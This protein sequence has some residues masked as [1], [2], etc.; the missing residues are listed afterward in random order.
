[1]RRL[2]PVLISITASACLTTVAETQCIRNVDCD[3]GICIDG[4]CQPGT[5]GGV[6]SSGGGSASGGGVGTTGGGST[7]GGGTGTTGGGGTTMGGG[8]GGGGTCGT[9]CSSALGCQ[10]GTEPFACGS[11]SAQCVACSFGEQCVN[12]ACEMTACGPMTCAGCCANGF[13]VSPTNQSALGCG[14][15]GGACTTCMQGQSCVNG[16]C[17]TAPACGPTTCPNGCC[18]NGQ[19][20]PTQAQSRF[21]CGTAGQMCQQCAMGEACTNGVCAAPP[22]CG[23]MTCAGCCDNGQ[24]RMGSTGFAC[25][26]QGAMCQRCMM[27]QACNNG[28]CGGTT[29]PDAGTMAPG[30]GSPCGTTQDCQPPFAAVCIP[31]QFANQNTGYTGGYCT[32]SCGMGTACTTGSVCV[33]ETFFGTQQSNCRVSCN[34]PG[35]QS[36]CRTG[37]VCQPGSSSASPG[38]C[39]PRCNSQGVLA[40]CSQGQTCNMATGVCN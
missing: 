23:P 37:Y 24:C 5:G 20:L 3:A 28:S 36:S 16:Q 26:R 14:L 10:P 17:A 34:A 19:C 39:R 29:M 32:Q 40:T 11:N 22:S 31:E 25:G 15:G 9:G 8:T 30:V 18:I 38:F 7:S 1:M 12:G 2:L 27:G 33:T 6:G 35:T 13:C 21:S 4:S